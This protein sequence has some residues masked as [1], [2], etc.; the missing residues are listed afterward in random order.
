MSRLVKKSF[1]YCFSL[2]IVLLISLVTITIANAS[3]YS[4][5]EVL[6]AKYQVTENITTEEI[7]YGITHIK[8]KALSDSP[9]RKNAT[10]TMDGQSVNILNVP[11]NKEVRIVNWTMTNRVGWTKQTVRVM[12]EDF[13]KNNPGWVVLAAVNGDFFDINGNN[14]ALPYQTGGVAISNGEVYRSVTNTNTIGFTNNGTTNT[15]IAEEAFTTTN[16]ILS[17]YD[18]LNQVIYAKEVKFFN[19]EPTNG[20]I[21]IWFCYRDSEGSVIN[22]TAPINS[23]FSNVPMRV[24]AS[25]SKNV[26]AKGKIS[27]ILTEEQQMRYGQFAIQTND[28]IIQALIE[29]GSVVRVQ[30]ELTGAYAECDNIT[31]GGV[32]L[33]RDGQADESILADG[34]RHPRTCVGKKEDG[35]IVFMTV[36]GR[37]ESSKMYGM[38]YEELSAALTYYGCVEA[39]NL[40][41]GGSTTMIIRN[42]YGDFDVVNS[43]SDGSERNDSNSLL[44]VVPRLELTIKEITDT[45]VTIDYREPNPELKITDIVLTING[46]TKTNI[47]FPIVIDGLTS[48]TDY[49][50]DVTYNLNYK[51]IEKIGEKVSTKIKTGKK[52]PILQ[53][54]YYL[55]SGDV[56]TVYFDIV[57]SESSLIMI[58]V[59]SG[60]FFTIIKKDQRVATLDKNSLDLNDINISLEYNVASSTSQGNADT[61]KIERAYLISY[62]L[63]GGTID[64][65]VS[66]Y[67]S[68]EG[69]KQLPIAAKEGYKF[70]GW[71][72]NN[73]ML[74]SIPQGMEG[75]LVLEAI[76][77]KNKGCGKQDLALVFNSLALLAIP[78]LMFKKKH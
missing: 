33:L 24:L 72:I 20:E 16:H 8:D 22:K 36:D 61:Y 54:Y 58:N 39:Y 17:I 43:P 4:V 9:T 45:T 37:Q 40:D 44:V 30:K 75:D 60:R 18:E 19:E 63:N 76:F 53:D 47:K 55:V 26:Y 77:E 70:K 49:Q 56:V 68:K 7:G 66:Y 23:Y 10:N 14:L 64:N 69:I 21:A 15:L 62:K 65:L 50:I 1:I 12:A 13:E 11:S 48:K 73:Q 71:M 32:N 74:E 5:I 3:E 78:L 29:E 41:G 59:T 28:P 27:S 2:V 57:D 67:I 46:E 51:D 25:S 35:T 52:R 34:W 42:E 31:G 6:G 38:T